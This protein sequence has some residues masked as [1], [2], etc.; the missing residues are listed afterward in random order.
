[1][2]SFESFVDIRIIKSSRPTTLFIVVISAHTEARDEDYSRREWKLAEV[3]L[4]S[5]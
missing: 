2:Y 1:M 4:V 3:R 5:A